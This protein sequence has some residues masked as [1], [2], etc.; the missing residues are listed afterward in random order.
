MKSRFEI[1]EDDLSGDAI[2]SLLSDHLDNMHSISPPGSVHALGVD[3]LRE[4]DVTFWSAWQGNELLGCAALKE[5]DAEH[6]E[7]KSMRTV[8]AHRG[9]GVAFALLEHLTEIGRQRAYKR[10][11]LETGSTH[12]FEAARS[13]YARY[14]FTSCG[15]FADYTEDPHSAFMRMDL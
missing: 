3:R 13:L 8:E 1:R 14:G 12:A 2:V 5:L 15:P 7:V 4:P 6:G 10:L 9:K 11:S